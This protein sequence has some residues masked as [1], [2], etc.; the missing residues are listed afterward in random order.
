MLAFIT[1]DGNICHMAVQYNGEIKEI[2][3][4]EAYLEFQQRIA[5]V[6][7]IDRP[8]LLIGERGTGKELA[9]RRLHFMSS[10]W[11]KPL[12][13]V[14]C[15]ALPP[16]L[17]ESELFGYEKG[18]FTG[19]QATRK[20]RFEEAEGGTLFLDEIGLIP[21]ETQEKILRV[22]EYGTFERIGSSQTMETNARIIGAT[23]ADLKALCKEGKFKEDL[24]DRLSFEVLF[25][26]PLRKR[27]DDIMLLASYF[28]SKM[29]IECGVDDIP[30]FSDSVVQSLMSYS[31]P[32]NVR[33]L[34][35]VIER[36]V[37]RTNG[38]LIESVD[39]DPFKNPY[40]EEETKDSDE[41]VP[42]VFKYD[43]KSL[44]KAHE[45]IDISF[46]SRALDEADG[47]Q[48]VAAELLG[49]TYDQFRGLYRKYKNLL[50]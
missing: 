15:A 38:S 10:R 21:L 20:G 47:N 29:A 3:E 18:A 44:A 4:S 45:S 39:F 11:Q 50:K 14:N 12:V 46:I 43:L 7:A 30:T 31:W 28:A 23:N 2:G 26:P 25:L 37:Y 27:G 19:A 1:K 35:N 36:A 6:A 9:A 33:E 49:L 24:L 32:G 48:R 22:V 42:D 17:I 5:K 8:V 16:S 34:K 13:T 40:L 41:M